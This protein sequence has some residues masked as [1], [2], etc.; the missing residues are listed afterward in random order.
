MK[1]ALCLILLLLA[2]SLAA[3]ESIPGSGE[4]VITPDG[5]DYT[6]AYHNGTDDFRFYGSD[7]W[8]V[9]FDFAAA[10]TGQD[11]VFF[12]IDKALL[13]FPQTGDSVR[14]ELFN[15]VAG[16][17]GQRLA[18]A[19]AAVTQ[20]N[21][22]IDIPTVTQAN[23]VW[24]IVSYSTNFINRYVSASAGGGTRSYYL[25]YNAQNPYFQSF[26]N[27]GFNCEL[28]FGLGGS[29]QIDTPDLALMSF[30]FSGVIAPRED[31]YPA[32]SI[33][34]HSDQSINNARVELLIT[35]PLAEFS[36]SDTI[37]VSEQIP[38]RSQYIFNSQ[39]AGYFEH[40]LSLH[41]SPMQ[42]RVRAV[43][44]SELT[45]PGSDPTF[46]N[47]II[48]YMRSFAHEYPVYL[49]ENFLRQDNAAQILNVQ[50]QYTL[51]ALSVINYLPVLGD[52]LANLAASQRYHWYGF[53]SFPRT[54]MNG[55]L[56][57]NGYS[58]AYPDQY[59]A[60][61]AQAIQSRTFISTSD[62]RFVASATQDFLT[63][64]ITLSNT[65]THLYSTTT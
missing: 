23:V 62:C 42:I 38:P 19:N 29:F 13:Y 18:L 24:L 17:P 5:R 39:S 34:N 12:A 14:I 11:T 63:A 1:H 22:Q 33:Y 57:I 53:N 50:D 3:I 41:D 55:T 10:Y 64:T 43:L 51:P 30:G 7:K 20:N 15:E 6:F 27:A 25:N 45:A 2:M 44:K 26:A 36:I 9:R 46:N 52:S 40:R 4:R 8:A 61:S 54:V 28:L 60:L 65:D 49:V 16:L 48:R 59:Q 58:S 47:T 37:W 35:S 32:F 21:M 56:R 31:I